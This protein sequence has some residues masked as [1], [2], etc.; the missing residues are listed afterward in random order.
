VPS[1][2]EK[3]CLGEKNPLRLAVQGDTLIAMNVT[4]LQNACIVKIQN[5][6]SICESIYS[7]KFTFPTVQFNLRGRRAG[8]A[9]YHYNLIRLN[10]VLLIENK[11]AFIQDTPG[12]EAAHLIARQVYGMFISSHGAEWKKVMQVI[13]QPA[14]R[15]HDFEVKTNHV[16][17]CKC[18][19]K[20]YLSTT[21]HNAIQSGRRNY[22]C[23]VCKQYI[24][25]DN[26]N[27]PVFA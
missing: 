13:G 27:Q 16:Y 21:K 25:W 20:I 18:D 24:T 9:Y 22:F 7:T 8:V 5:A 1:G 4:E 11:E 12:H 6:Y 10:N 19:K 15:C 2:S 17:S 23:K 14:I 3:S 26:L